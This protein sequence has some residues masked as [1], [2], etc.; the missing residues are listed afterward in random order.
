MVV[1]KLVSF[2]EG[3]FSGVQV[4]QGLVSCLWSFPSSQVVMLFSLLGY[5][6][7]AAVGW[8]DPA[9]LVPAS[10]VKLGRWLR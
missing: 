6:G 2:W 4:I 7:L 5:V 10:I 1:G 9:A 8:F 3:L